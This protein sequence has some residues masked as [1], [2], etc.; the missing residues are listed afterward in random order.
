MNGGGG[1]GGG[2]AETYGDQWNPF[3]NRNS[4]Y[5][6]NPNWGLGGLGG[7]NMNQP[8]GAGGGG[9]PGIQAIDPRQN[10]GT[11]A[12][13]SPNFS[14]MMPQGD[15]GFAPNQT[16]GVQGGM[17]DP[18][19]GINGQ[20][21]NTQ[22]DPFTSTGSWNGGLS[23]VPGGGGGTPPPGARIDPNGM[24]NKGAYNNWSTNNGGV[25][26]QNGGGQNMNSLIQAMRFRPPNRLAALG[27][28]TFAG[29]S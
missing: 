27:N 25:M 9:Y 14:S 21:G 13:G 6:P 26:M 16:Y 4:M 24:Q 5:R 23:M 3:D 15:Q 8:G 2:V 19:F 22:T 12:Q 29:S 17:V 1:M 18:N 28:P 20:A 10:M 11:Y 7:W